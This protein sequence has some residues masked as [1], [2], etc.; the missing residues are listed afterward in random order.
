[1]EHDCFFSPGAV[2]DKK[3]GSS[4]NIMLNFNIKIQFETFLLLGTVT[5]CDFL[6]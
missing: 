2:C 5:F 4:E 3:K 1:M 6:N